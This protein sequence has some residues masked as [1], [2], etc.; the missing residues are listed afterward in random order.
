MDEDELRVNFDR[1]TQEIME[2]FDDPIF[3][4]DDRMMDL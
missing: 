4:H 3:W 1:A 2:V